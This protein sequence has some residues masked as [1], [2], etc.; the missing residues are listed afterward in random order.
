MTLYE[1]I[2]LFMLLEAGCITPGPNNALLSS[3]GMRFG[4]KRT[5]PH[6]WGI[7][8]GHAFM[9]FFVAAGLGA[10]YLSFPIFKQILT[11]V[12][13]VLLCYLAYKIATAPVD[14][15]AESDRQSKPWT[16]W[17]GFAFQWINPKA[18][19]I[20]IGVSGQYASG[21]HPIILAA[22]IAIATFFAGIISS[23]TWT[24]FGVAMAR[25]LNT[26]AK[27]RAFNI[28]MALLIILSI[29]MLLGHE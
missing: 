24:I 6:A 12:A 20:A 8:S 23:Q 10:V 15:F 9:E 18:W 1:F 17:Q 16:F 19:L 4:F 2:A 13:I 28:I 7:T 25:I 21:D 22:I 3:S 29:F 14:K 27:R 5:Q 26:P 11:V